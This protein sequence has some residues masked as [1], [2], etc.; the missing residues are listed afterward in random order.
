MLVG[1]VKSRVGVNK[2]RKTSYYSCQGVVYLLTEL[3]PKICK[4]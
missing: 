4:C 3:L 2:E 1:K